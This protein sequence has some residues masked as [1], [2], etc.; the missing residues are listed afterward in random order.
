MRRNQLEVSLQIAREQ[1][2]ERQG[3]VPH[4]QKQRQP[5]PA[6][7]EPPHIKRNFLGK[8][9]GPDDQE[10]RERKV[11]PHHHG[12]QQQFTQ[13]M[14]VPVRENAAHGFI[15]R[16]Q[17]EQRDQEGHR[18][19]PLAGNEE[20]TIH[21]REPVRFQRHHP[22]DGHERDRDAPEQ[23]A[24]PRQRGHLLVRHRTRRAIFIL[25]PAVQVPRA[26]Q[27]AQKIKHRA[28][29]EEGEIQVHRLV[30]QHRIRRYDVGMRPG[31]Q[32]RNADRDGDEQQRQQ[33][34]CP[35]GRFRGTPDRYAPGAAGQ[36]LHHQ[37]RQAAQRNTQKQHVRPQVRA[38]ELARRS[39][40]RSQQSQG[41]RDD[42]YRAGARAPLFEIAGEILRDLEIHHL[43]H[44]FSPPGAGVGL[45]SCP[46]ASAGTSLTPAL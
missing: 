36:I 23:H 4:H 35:H 8:I 44:H 25:R 17:H 9:A 31:I 6:A 26:E 33:R 1:Q 20:Q 45:S 34:Q 5:P 2:R 19:K 41:Q 13:V 39:H 11:R 15:L 12:G 37:P 43:R 40:Q 32:R 21:G 18:R 30:L 38:E 10:L 22:I 24:G 28:A 42:A 14:Q 27:P 7:R 3:K 46:R 16:K 29:Q